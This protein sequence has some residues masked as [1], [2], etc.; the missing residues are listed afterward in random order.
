MPFNFTH[1]NFCDRKQRDTK[2]QA[3]GLLKLH[4]VTQENISRTNEEYKKEADKK[5]VGR[6]SLKAGDLVWVYLK[7]ERLPQLRKNKLMPRTAGPLLITAKLGDNTYQVDLPADYNVTNTFNTGNLQ[8]CTEEQ[9]LRTILLQE[10][11]IEPYSYPSEH[12]PSLGELQAVPSRQVV[13]TVPVQKHI[14]KHPSLEHDENNK[15]HHDQDVQAQ[16]IHE[17]PRNHKTYSSS[18]STDQ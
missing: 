14:T 13:P 3:E 4:R 18:Q 16:G 2:E 11:R 1:V 17:K 6:E 12:G 15:T 5:N 10:G 8:I 9:E 7:N